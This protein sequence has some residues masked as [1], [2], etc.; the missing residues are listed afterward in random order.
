MTNRTTSISASG[1]LKFAFVPS[2]TA[3]GTW[4]Q[5]LRSPSIDVTEVVELMRNLRD[6]SSGT[7]Q[8]L[9]VVSWQL[10]R[11]ARAAGEM[12]LIPSVQ[13][14]YALWSMMALSSISEFV[15]ILATQGPRTRLSRAQ[16][17][18]YLRGIAS[19]PG[20]TR[21]DSADFEARIEIVNG[22]LIAVSDAQLISGMSLS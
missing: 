4:F 2:L 8:S 12:G 22:I 3:P 11:M 7:I 5:L 1:L 15:R 21:D 9:S 13:G 6:S 16:R 14:L 19:K 10:E 18:A 20:V 17:L